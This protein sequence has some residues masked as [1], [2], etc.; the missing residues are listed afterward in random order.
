MAKN[1]ATWTHIPLTQLSNLLHSLSE[2]VFIRA[3]SGKGGGFQLT[4]PANKISLLK[5][6]TS[7]KDYN[8]F[9]NCRLGLEECWDER[10]C[11]AHALWKVEKVRIKQKLQELSLEDISNFELRKDFPTKGAVILTPSVEAKAR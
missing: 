2:S 3:K 8:F 1:I 11:Q 7:V 6:A 10:C 4:R 9:A 5:V